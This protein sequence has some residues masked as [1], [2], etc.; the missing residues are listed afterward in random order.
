MERTQKKKI[1]KKKSNDSKKL[2]KK[3]PENVQLNQKKDV[4]KKI[5]YKKKANKEPNKIKDKE[6]NKIKPNN[7]SIPV[8]AIEAHL[9]KRGIVFRR[10]ATYS[11]CRDK[12][13]LPF[14]FELIINGRVALIEYDGEQHF[15]IVSK[16]HGTGPKAKSKYEKGRRHDRTKTEYAYNNQISLLRI[17]SEEKENVVE[18]VD[19]F[20]AALHKPTYM[21]SNNELYKEHINL[22]KSSYCCLQ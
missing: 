16:F 7:G 10:E 12:N 19:K 8:Q 15:V 22:C 2:T 5:V 13:V 9:R 11:N 21:F 6:P 3:V 14:D 17:S 18:W 20:I 1:P 4:K